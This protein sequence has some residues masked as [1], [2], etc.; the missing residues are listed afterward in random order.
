[1]LVRDLMVEDV[2]SVSRDATVKDAVRTM[3]EE[4]V[5]SVIVTEEE[6][7]VG[8]FT[9]SD[10]LATG[11]DCDCPFSDISVERGMSEDL[12]TGDP[13]MTVRSAA[14]EMSEAGVRKLPIVEDFEVV[15]IIT[16]T[17]IVRA[18]ATL[19]DEAYGLNVRRR[20]WSFEE[21][22]D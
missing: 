20:K 12:V 3:L 17:D 18:H 15:G 6:L 2:I 22:D 7:P 5:G 13:D 1:M 10:A 8:I 11:Y 14:T 21:E 19:I 16:F 4:R 9:G